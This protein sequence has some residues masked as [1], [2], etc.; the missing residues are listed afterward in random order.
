EVEVT[1]AVTRP[2]ARAP[3]VSTPSLRR[4]ERRRWEDFFSKLAPP[5]ETND[6]IVRDTYHFAW[7]MLWSN[8][9]AGVGGQVSKPFTSPARLHYG[10]QWWW[11]EAFSSIVFRHLRDPKIA[12]E[13]L[14][15]FRVA[16]RPDG[17]I[18]GLL[19]YI[20]SPS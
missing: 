11:D 3:R 16:Q 15:N 17:M 6:P 9:C 4:G 13:F 10:A 19:N 1:F 18:P 12:Y 20:P 14:D 8:R 5:I 7:Q 2:T